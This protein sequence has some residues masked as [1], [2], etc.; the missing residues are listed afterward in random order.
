MKYFFRTLFSCSLLLINGCINNIIS[1]SAT[2]QANINTIENSISSNAQLMSVSAA[3]STI[4]PAVLIPPLPLPNAESINEEHFD[5][6]ADSLPA[7]EFF[8]GLVQGTDYNMIVHKEVGGNISLKLK[9]VTVEEVMQVVQR[10]YGYEYVKNGNIYQVF[11]ASLQTEIFQIN[12]LDIERKGQSDTQVSAGSISTSGNSSSDSGSDSDTVVSTHITT[13]TSANF[14]SELKTTLETIVNGDGRNIVVTP[15]SGVIVVR[16]LPSEIAVVREYLAKT[17]LILHR[18]VIIEAKILEITLNDGFQSGIN[19]T[20]LGRPE[21]GKTINLSQGSSTL[22]SQNNMGGILTADLNLHDFTAVI[23]L[24]ETQGS[25]QVLS[26]PHVSTVNNQKAV[27]KVGTDEFFVTSVETTTTT[28]TSTTST[29][30]IDLTPFFSGIALD[31]TPQVSENGKIVLH[32]HPTVSEVEDQQKDISIGSENFRIPLAQ[33]SIRES[34]SIVHAQ[35][36][37]IIIIGG[38]MK[39]MTND[40]Q[41][42][43]PGLGDIPAIGELF[44]QR[45]KTTYKTELVILLRPV[46]A[47]TDSLQDELKSSLKLFKSLQ[48]LSGQ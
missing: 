26:S 27:I 10:V 7:H 35:S 40:S 8:M 48:P 15:Q 29:P 11:P 25:V 32:I 44:K 19:W 47:T 43:V 20:A 31:V 21:N 30:S 4:A 18:Q 24:L 33:S 14:W 37:Q 38:L 12:Y 1:D 23:K 42:K 28:G 5:I 45:R 46:L 36:G 6:T 39:S 17:E 22:N 2:H 3:T 9:N 34:D 41:A 13:K 16:A